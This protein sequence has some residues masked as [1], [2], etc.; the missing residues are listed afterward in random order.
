MA[1]RHEFNKAAYRCAKVQCRHEN[2]QGALEFIKVGAWPASSSIFQ[3]NR[4]NT[5]IDFQLLRRWERTS[6]HSPGTSLQS[7]LRTVEDEGADWGCDKGGT[8]SGLNKIGEAAFQRAFTEWTYLQD[9][10]SATYGKLDQHVCPAEYHG[11]HSVH[12]D[13][14]MKVHYLYIGGV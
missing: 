7:F 1:G 10:V 11:Y 3:P 9:E 5:V 13:G 12:I 6:N 14:N 8:G 2:M 4:L